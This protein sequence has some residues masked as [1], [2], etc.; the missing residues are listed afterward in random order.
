MEPVLIDLAELGR[1]AGVPELERIAPNGIHVTFQS[2]N[3]TYVQKIITHLQKIQPEKLILTGHVDPWVTMSV[4]LSLNASE[5]YSRVPTGDMRLEPLPRGMYDTDIITMHQTDGDVFLTFDGNALEK[6]SGSPEK[7]RMDQVVL[8]DVGPGKNIYLVADGKFPHQLAVAYS[9]SR[10]C[11]RFYMGTSSSP[12]CN[13]G[14]YY[15]CK[16]INESI[17]DTIA[18]KT[19]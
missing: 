5:L 3:G 17:G 13:T 9:L 14:V 10:E 18:R 7:V 11:K 2:W 8:P 1:E 19:L 6:K 4:I 12:S 16:G 15:C